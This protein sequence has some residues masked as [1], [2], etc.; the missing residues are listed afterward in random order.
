MFRFHIMG[1]KQ[2]TIAELNIHK[3]LQQ[4]NAVCVLKARIDDSYSLPLM[5]SNALEVTRYCNLITLTSKVRDDNC[6]NSNWITVTFPQ[7]GC[8]T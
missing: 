8:V 4:Y 3:H 7:A 6:K 1:E 5:G 2:F